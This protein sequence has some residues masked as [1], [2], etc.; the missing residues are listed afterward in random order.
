MAPRIGL[1]A[2]VGLGVGLGAGSAGAAAAGNPPASSSAGSVTAV[3]G[4][5]RLQIA[6]QVHARNLETTLAVV[7]DY[8][9]VPFKPETALSEI[10]GDFGRQVSLSAPAS[11]VAALDPQ[12]GDTPAPPLW[13]FS[14]GLRSLDEAQRAAQTAGFITDGKPGA[15]RLALQVQNHKLPCYLSAGPAGTARLSCGK[16][17]RDRDLLGPYLAR[18]APPS[19]PGDLHAEVAVDTIVRSYD[20]AWQRLLGMVGL[21][22]P[23][24]LQ[25]GEPGFD[26]ALT[27]ATQALVGQ[28]QAMSRDLQSLSADLTLTKSGIDARIAYRMTGQSS[29]WAQADAE[30]AARSSAGAP[31]TFWAMASDVSSASFQTTDPKYARKVLGL[32]LPLLD[33]YLTYDGMA[34]A[35]RQALM[36]ALSKL[37]DG[38]PA[39]PLTSVMATGKSDQ[40]VPAPGTGF[41]P[42]SLLGNSFY[43]LA[44]EGP[45][46]WVVPSLKALVAAYNRPG[47][48]SYLR[49]KWKKLDPGGAMPTLKVDPIPKTVGANA[50]GLVFS[51]NLAALVRN[52]GKPVSPRPRPMTLHMVVL[53]T[54]GRTWTAFGADRATLLRRLGEQAKLPP[55][56]TLEQRGGLDALRGSGLRSG[57]FTSLISLASYLDAALASSS[58]SSAREPGR[59][60]SSAQLFSMAPHHGEVPMTYLSRPDK[61]SGKVVS[62]EILVQV[63]RMVIE[64]VAA[65]TMQLAAEK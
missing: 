63:P 26:R 18:L 9:P 56:K 11:L 17:E 39:G 20:S 41:D 1:L 10:F 54:A 27:D 50:Y 64:D 53:P 28:V 33:G 44:S 34:P 16:Q 46:D 38:A 57:G 3:A 65:L 45:S 31:P 23:Q 21:L 35:D 61:S 47:V 55:A 30:A 58:R 48:Q 24:R 15:Q 8:I 51:G 7:K 6:A 42:A 4:G 40:T 59:V 12:S 43:L 36:D 5:D 37:T 25:L 22:V 14:V 52:P 62:S 13:G 29:W 49:T 60:Q 2:L 19:L 32:L